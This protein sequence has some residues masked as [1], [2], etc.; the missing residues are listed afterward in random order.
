MISGW[1]ISASLFKYRVEWGAGVHTRSPGWD[2]GQLALL[3]VC[4]VMGFP[5]ERGVHLQRERQPDPG[6]Q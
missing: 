3:Q 2:A 6:P 1:T 5:Q 4:S